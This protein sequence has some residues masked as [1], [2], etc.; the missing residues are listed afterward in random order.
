MYILF[1]KQHFGCQNRKK[2]SL[3]NETQTTCYILFFYNYTSKMI[4]VLLPSSLPTNTEI[5]FHHMCW[6]IFQ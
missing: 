4:G 5:L 1:D 3:A 6:D 2:K